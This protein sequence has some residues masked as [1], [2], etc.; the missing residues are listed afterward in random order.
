MS[1]FTTIICQQCGKKRD[2]RTCNLVN[3]KGKYCSKKCSNKNNHFLYRNQSLENNPRWKG[4]KMKDGF[5]YIL[6][7][8]RNHPKTNSRGYVREHILVMEKYLGRYLKNKEIVHHNNSIKNDNRIK[9]LCLF[10]NDNAH[11]HWHKFIRTHGLKD[12]QINFQELYK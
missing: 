2:Y 12:I 9:N 5:G 8:N 3:G 1:K 11:K 4:G 6:I 10:K 7:K